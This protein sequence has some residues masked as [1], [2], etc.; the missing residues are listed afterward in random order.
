MKKYAVIVAGGSGSRM[1]SA[2]P[3]QF[4][5]LHNRPVLFY[6]MEAFLKAFSDLQVI[7]VLPEDFVEDGNVLA[8]QSSDAGRI[9]IAPGGKTRFDSVKKGLELVKEESIVFVHDG[10]RCLV[11]TD[12]IRSCYLQAKEKGSAIPAIPVTD[13]VRVLTANGSQ[14]LNRDLLRAVQ[15]PQTFQSAIILKAFDQPYR[16]SFTDEATVAEAAG[17][18]VHL[19]EGDKRNIK[20]TLPEDLLIAENLMRE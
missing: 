13:S 5:L 18:A 17:F 3:K 7:L 4:L 14:P 9:Q 1:K 10:V 6:T 12:L 20:I 16:Q 2:T 19:V 15:T 8:E 11:S